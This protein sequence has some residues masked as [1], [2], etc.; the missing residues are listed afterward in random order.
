MDPQLIHR[1]IYRINH[2]QKSSGRP[3]M[4]YSNCLIISIPSIRVG[5][6]SFSPLTSRTHTD[7]RWEGNAIDVSVK[8]HTYEIDI[9]IFFIR[10]NIMDAP[11]SR[12]PEAPVW[13][14]HEKTGLVGW[15]QTRILMGYGWMQRLAV[16]C[17]HELA[18][19]RHWTELTWLRGLATG[20]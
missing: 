16:G 1:S 18:K 3:G 19:I 12:E 7:H 2:W 8:Y 6:S 5:P 14:V 20:F 9:P 15:L 10:P 4:A 11:E 13:I 17:R